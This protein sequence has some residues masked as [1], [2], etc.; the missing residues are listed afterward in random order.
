MS[1][2]IYGLIGELIDRMII[3]YDEEELL[4]I[5]EEP[6]IVS[7]V[8]CILQ[9]SQKRK[10]HIANLEHPLEEARRYIIEYIEECYV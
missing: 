5:A 3:Y 10:V 4:E 7:I 2:E 9:V 6:D 1:A 8:A